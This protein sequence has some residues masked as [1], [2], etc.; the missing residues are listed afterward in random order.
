M[1]YPP[2]GPA[3]HLVLGDWNAICFFCGI[4]AK[5]SELRRHWEGFYV[6]ERC[7]EPRQPQDFVR[8]VPDKQV[9]PWTQPEGADIFTNMGEALVTDDG[10]GDDHTPPD[11]L[12]TDDY[13]ILLTDEGTST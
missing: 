12:M 1:G 10:E 13:S 7:W 5:A 6:C 9:P 8:G 2:K 4:K 3:D 11:L